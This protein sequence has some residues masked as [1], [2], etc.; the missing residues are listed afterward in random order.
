VAGIYIVAEKGFVE[1]RECGENYVSIY[2]G[3]VVA[4][5]TEPNWPVGRGPSLRGVRCDCIRKLHNY[6]IDS[7][8]S[9]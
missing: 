7:I 3:V 6:F 9:L 5:W 1:N 4:Q 2:L 8:K